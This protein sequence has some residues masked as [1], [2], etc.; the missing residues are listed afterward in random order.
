MI[1]PTAVTKIILDIMNT[2]ENLA[3]LG[4][5]KAVEGSED[6]KT[7]DLQP[8]YAIVFSSFEDEANILDFGNPEAI[9]VTI[10]VAIASGEYKTV[11]ESSEEVLEIAIKVIRLLQDDYDYTDSEDVEHTFHLSCKP[12]P[13]R[14]G[15]KS[16]A[17]SSIICFFT[18]NIDYIDA[19]I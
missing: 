2:T 16:A 15:V 8:P 3:A 1:L 11:M 5:T 17:L 19:S 4:I 7:E 14:F 12:L 9:P 10:G 6:L 13:L 18:Y